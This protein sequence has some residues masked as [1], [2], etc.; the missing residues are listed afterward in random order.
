MGD[1]GE[2]YGTSVEAIY[3]S[4]VKTDGSN[5]PFAQTSSSHKFMYSMLG[6]CMMTYLA[7]GRSV[8]LHGRLTVAPAGRA[9]RC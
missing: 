8:P 9:S 6:G 5:I 7:G 1:G 3:L 4:L 2:E